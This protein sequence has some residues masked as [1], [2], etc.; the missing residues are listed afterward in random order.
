MRAL[1]DVNVLVALLD[2]QHVA[3]AA[4]HQWLAQ[5]LPDGWASCPITENGCVRILAN[6]KYPA[7]VA[8]DAV[9]AKLETARAT[10]RHEFWAD[11]VSL[12]DKAIFDPSR[13]RGHQQI[14]DAYLLALAV[15]H[16][17]RLVS[18]D[19]GIRLDAVVGARPDHLLVLNATAVP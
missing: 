18:F 17:G 16:G 9:V 10:P 6:P 3:H 11:D 4:A 19:Q 15:K 7:P 1:L 2:R 12:T 13:I 14:T 8:A 5:Q